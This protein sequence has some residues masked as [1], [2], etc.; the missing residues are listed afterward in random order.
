MPT[1]GKLSPDR[2]DSPV[3]T[4]TVAGFPGSIVTAPIAR[5]SAVSISAVQLRPPLSERNRPP[6]AVPKHVSRRKARIV[7]VYSG[8]SRR[9][10]PE[11][12]EDRSPAGGAPAS[13][14]AAA[15]ACRRARV[16]TGAHGAA[17]RAGL[18]RAADRRD[19]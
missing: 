17:E 6:C 12:G 7:L 15:P 16:A 1:P 4:Q 8:P 2:L 19:L 18:H 11:D 5:V 9:E 3:P 13:T 10:G 14:G